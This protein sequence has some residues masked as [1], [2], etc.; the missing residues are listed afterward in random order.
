MD[1][2]VAAAVVVA[3]VVVSAAVVAFVV[4]AASAVALAAL[5]RELPETDR[6]RLHLDLAPHKSNSRCAAVSAISLA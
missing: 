4:V 3:A 5:A 1:C 6:S 2:L